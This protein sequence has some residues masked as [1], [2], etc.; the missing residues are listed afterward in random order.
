MSI[1][2]ANNSAD[3]CGE[4]EPCG[5]CDLTMADITIDYLETDWDDP[6]ALKRDIQELLEDDCARYAKFLLWRLQ[7]LV[8]HSMRIEKLRIEINDRI[9]WGNSRNQKRMSTYEN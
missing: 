4:N 8:P 7:K 9:F 1:Q 3:C 2:Q 5:L 6:K